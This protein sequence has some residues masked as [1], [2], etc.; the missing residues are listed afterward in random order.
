MDERKGRA[1]ADRRGLPL[2]GAVGVPGDAYKQGLIDH[3][4]RVLTEMRQHGFRISDQFVAR[5]ES[6]LETRYAR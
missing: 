6:L 1:V 3:P 2:T 4:Q 5:F